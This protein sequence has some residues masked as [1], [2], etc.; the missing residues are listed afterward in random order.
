MKATLTLMFTIII[1]MCT[2]C[3]SMI[4]HPA[5]IGADLEFAMKNPKVAQKVLDSGKI[6]CDWCG[7]PYKAKTLR[8]CEVKGE[9]Y[10]QLMCKDCRKWNKKIIVKT[11]KK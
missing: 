8:W 4:N 5:S 11:S 10:S 6:W 3:P 9:D 2:V 7:E 1:S